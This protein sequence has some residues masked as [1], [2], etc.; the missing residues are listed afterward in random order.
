MPGVD[1]NGTSGTR[2][3][4]VVRGRLSN[5]F[6]SA[7]SGMVLEPGEGTTALVGDVADQ[8]QLFGVLERVR[9]FGLELL[10]VEVGD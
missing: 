1:G 10:R 3:R 2:Y 5:R 8:A 7:F 4:I 9:D 6:A